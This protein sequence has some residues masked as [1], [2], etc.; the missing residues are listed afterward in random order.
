[1]P[2]V[3]GMLCFH[4]PS[5]QRPSLSDLFNIISALGLLSAA[6]AVEDHH[7]S[8]LHRRADPQLQEHSQAAHLLE[9]D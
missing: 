3:I 7:L 5:S 2:L 8:V 6:A 9:T 1:M 4:K